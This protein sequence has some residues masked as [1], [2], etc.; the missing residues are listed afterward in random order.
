MIFRRSLG[1]AC[2]SACWLAHQAFWKLARCNNDYKTMCSHRKNGSFFVTPVPC[3]G[4]QFDEVDLH[5]SWRCLYW[6]DAAMSIPTRELIGKAWS[7][8]LHTQHPTSPIAQ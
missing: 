1:L 5:R 3:C 7:A 2:S 8:W 4:V 6:E